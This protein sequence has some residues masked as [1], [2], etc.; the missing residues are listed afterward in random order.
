MFI[1]SFIIRLQKVFHGSE[2]YYAF[3]GFATLY[4]FLYFPDKIRMRI[5]QF[6][7]LPIYERQGH[8]RM[9]QLLLF[10]NFNVYC[11]LENLYT[12]IMQDLRL[13]PNIAEISGKKIFLF[14][15]FYINFNE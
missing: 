9:I 10:S 5:S 2:I 3:I 4:A 6:L 12:I 15:F 13:K 8:G 1:W 11:L 14:L 7:I